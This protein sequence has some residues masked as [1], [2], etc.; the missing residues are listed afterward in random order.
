MENAINALDSAGKAV[1]VAQVSD[2][3]LCR[4]HRAGD[5][6]ACLVADERADRNVAPRQFRND[7]ACEF[8][9]GSHD[10]NDGLIAFHWAS[11]RYR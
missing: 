10:Q 3:D 2:G 6:R 11:P 9:G 4:A 8:A 5:D 7:H 1:S